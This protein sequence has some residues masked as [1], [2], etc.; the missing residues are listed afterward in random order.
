MNDICVD[1]GLMDVWILFNPTVR[2][3]TFKSSLH[4]IFKRIDYFRN[5]YCNLL[6]LH[7]FGN[8]IISDQFTV[9][10]RIKKSPRW[11]LNCCTVV[12]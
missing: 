10:C 12:F 3:Y 6:F 1:L 4:N 7:Q 8:I 9:F 2:D 5:H 11:T